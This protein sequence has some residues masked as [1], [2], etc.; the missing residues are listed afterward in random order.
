MPFNRTYLEYLEQL[1]SGAATALGNALAYEQER[2]RA[3]ALAEIDHA[4]TQFFA[5]V[6]HEFRTP[7]ALML[8]PV[9]AV[10]S[11]GPEELSDENREQFRIVR[12]DSFRLL[13]LVNAL[14]DFSRVEAGRAQ[15][16]FEPTDL[17]KLTAELA[18]NFRSAIESAGIE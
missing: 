5:N 2:K 15:A 7:L 1:T 10:L 16:A 13:K 18:A 14:L 9:E 17:A 12:R 3:K 6:S 8:G 4:K 11:T